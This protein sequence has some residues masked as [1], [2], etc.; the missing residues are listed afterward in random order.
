[1]SFKKLFVLVFA[2]VLICV[3]PTTALANMTAPG[4]FEHELLIVGC[5][6][7]ETMTITH[8]YEDGSIFVGKYESMETTVWFRATSREGERLTELEGD[9]SESFQIEVTF[10]DGSVQQSNVMQFSEYVNYIY[11][12]NEN[13]LRR[14][15]TY[16]MWTS[17]GVLLS[18]IPA[19]VLACVVTIIIECLA[20]ML[21][22]LKPT[23]YVYYVNLVSNPFMNAF[24][25][26]VMS[27][28]RFKYIWIVLVLE[29]LVVAAEYL[30]YIR[31]YK[32]LGKLRL[33]IF[34][35]TANALS[36]GVYLLL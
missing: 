12:V 31:L 16:F 20:S 19:A 28:F 2:V 6:D 1:M 21:F 15:Y 33:F 10:T 14:S 11:D 34:S 3:F 32:D 29:I 9:S 35:L 30:V 8:F 27:F 23:R 18:W 5:K 24:L 36:F 25:L 26:L 4:P 17:G 13:M 22:R 7:V